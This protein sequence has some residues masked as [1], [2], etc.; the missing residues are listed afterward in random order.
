MSD[1]LKLI[2]IILCALTGGIIGA[3]LLG[4]YI[5]WPMAILGGPLGLVIGALF[6][7]YIPWYEWFT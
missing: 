3:I 2:Y 5:A 6:G 1:G 7:K 4:A